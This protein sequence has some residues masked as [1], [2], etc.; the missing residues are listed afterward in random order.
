M[1]HVWI[2]NHYSQEPN[3][4]GGTRHYSLAR[5][6]VDHGWRATILAASTDHGSGAQRLSPSEAFRFEN[7]GGVDFLW[8]W[9]RKYRGNGHQRVRNMLDYTWSVLR[10][11]NLAMLSKPDAIIGSSVHPFAAWAGRRLARRFGVP[12]IFEVRDLWPQTLIDMGRLSEGSIAAKGLRWLEKSLYRSASK[13]IVLLPRAGDYIVPLG[14]P[15]EKV[16]WIPNG[17]DIDKFFVRPA[18]YAAEK[19]TLMYLGSHGAANGLDTLLKAMKIVEL[20]PKGGKIVLRI[21]GDGSL[22]ATLKATAKELGLHKV[23]FEEP[24]AK[25]DIPALAAEADAFVICVPDRPKL[26]RYGI[27][28]NKIFDYMAAQRPTIIASNAA[29]NPIAEAGAGITVPPE[30]AEKLAAAIIEMAELPAERR[31][32]MGKAARHHL[33]SNYGMSRLA[34]QL[35]QTLDESLRS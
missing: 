28:A 34:A 25:A 4:P 3:A 16:V 13:I 9:A 27:S 7:K 6:L 24:V 12:F 21:V 15:A 31:C 26:Y 10:P 11:K 8:L 14:I 2:L 29:N 22:K 33:E 32:A 20:H 1:K 19:F 17:V 18:R 30:N 5:N 23:S 35:A